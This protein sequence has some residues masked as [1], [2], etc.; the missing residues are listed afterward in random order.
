MGNV[1]DIDLAEKLVPFTERRSPGEFNGRAL[2]I[3]RLNAG[4][5]CPTD[6]SRAEFFHVIK[7]VLE[8]DLPRQTE[9]LRAGEMF[10]V[11][12]GTPCEAVAL[13]DLEVM[14]IAEP[15]G[16]GRVH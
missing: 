13:A 1:K 14:M 5:P 3:R 6:Q 8:L 16:T 4:D 12:A 15:A 2:A 7:G 10:V 11:P 9:T